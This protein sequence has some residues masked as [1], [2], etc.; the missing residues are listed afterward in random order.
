MKKKVYIPARF[1]SS[2]LPGKPLLKIAGKEM[3]L[4]VCERV[5]EAVGSDNL[6]VLTDDER[7]YNLVVAAGFSASMTPDDCLTGTDR[8][9][10]ALKHND[11]DVAINVQG[12]EPLIPI[13]DVKRIFDM[14][15]ESEI[16]NC[17]TAITGTSD[18]N[19]STLPK[20]VFDE[21]NYLLYMS[22]API[23]NNKDLT[24]DEGYKQVCIYSFPRRALSLYGLGSVKTPLESIEDIEILRLL[25][26]G[27]KIKMIEAQSTIAVDVQADLDKV[28]S[29]IND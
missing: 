13:E 19:R 27:W 21:E 25:E 6:E 24:G 20:V 10:E 17:Y 23:P 26:K 1:K 29:I 15:N 3:I 5:A 16:L 28:E 18:L 22:R 11:I 9:A 4:H 2:R 8:I 7:I 12:D 14:A